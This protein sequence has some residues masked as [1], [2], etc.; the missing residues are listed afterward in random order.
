MELIKPIYVPENEIF[1]H[2]S[3]CVCVCVC[4]E[5]RAITNYCS[6]TVPLWQNYDCTRSVYLRV[7][8]GVYLWM[9]GWRNGYTASFVLY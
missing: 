8:V 2:D 3:V 9:G 5:L 7:D 1:C 4:V 6:R